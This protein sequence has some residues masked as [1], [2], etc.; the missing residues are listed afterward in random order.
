MTMTI[1]NLASVGNVV[2]RDYRHVSKV[3]TPAAPL[4]LPNAYHKWYVLRR[5]DQ[6]VSPAADAEARTFLRTETSAD[7]LPISGDLGFVVHHLSGEYVHLLLVCTW[8]NDNEM[9]E[10][11][12]CRDFREEGTFRLMPQGTHRGVICVWE[13]GPVAHEHQAWTRYLRSERDKAA[14][15]AYV[16]SQVSGTI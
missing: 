12:Y 8:R 6:A 3:F 15:R 1:D 4:L 5:A 7:R 9:W 2:D 11:S 16:E 13:F 14:K 10:T